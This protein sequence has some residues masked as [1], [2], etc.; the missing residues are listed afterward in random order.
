M[1]GRTAARLLSSLTAVDAAL[2]DTILTLSG[3]IYVEECCYRDCMPKSWKLL[4][5]LNL[6]QPEK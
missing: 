3:A 5:V 6:Y 1:C 2:P 4:I